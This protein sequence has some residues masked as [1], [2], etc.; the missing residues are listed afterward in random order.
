MKQYFFLLP[1]FVLVAVACNNEGKGTAAV[2]EKSADSLFEQVVHGHDVGMAKDLALEKAITKTQHMLDSINALPSVVRANASVYKQELD[3]LLK[4]LQHA[5][6]A[7]D[8]WM[9]EMNWDPSTIEVNERI[10]YLSNE[11]IKID[12]ISEAILGS[13]ARADSLLKKTSL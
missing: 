8:K 6:F 13:L 4:N 2:L 3:T 9:K 5:D 11:K 12:K 1:L 10:K 7:M